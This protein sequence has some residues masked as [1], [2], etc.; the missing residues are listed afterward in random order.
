MKSNKIAIAVLG[1]TVLAGCAKNGVEAPVLPAFLSGS[2]SS[3]TA[4]VPATATGTAAAP[5]LGTPDLPPTA[6]PGECFAR[7]VTPAKFETVQQRVERAPATQRVEV[8]PAQYRTV[9][10]QV[11]VTE[12]SERIEVV[13]ATYRTVTETVIVE[14]ERT[15]IRTIPA[16]FRTVDER[17]L[18][19]PARTEW[20]KGAQPF[21]V[22]V[23]DQRTTATGDVMCLV[24][25]PAQYKTVSKRVVDRPERTERIVIP[26]VTRQISKRVVD[27]PASTR[28]VAVPATTRTVQVQELVSPASERVVPVPA[29]F[30]TVSTRREVASAKTEWVSVLCDTN[31][32]P[33]TV[34]RVQSK[35]FEMGLYRGRVDGVYG[36]ATAQAIRAY[37]ARNGLVGNGAL[38]LETIEKLGISI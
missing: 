22:P 10:K 27:R 15:E 8:V 2:S 13:P 23:L 19:A 20:K 17:V 28:A 31:T 3:E 38:T 16:T 1:L 30:E 5:G 32:A 7:V 33:A 25:V 26:A 29:S 14:P 35:L 21:G 37:Q 4:A 34:R 11:V 18:V 9:T 12:A 24:Q 36:P 6:K